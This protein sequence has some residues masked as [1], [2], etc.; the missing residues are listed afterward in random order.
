MRTRD[1][2]SL[3]TGTLRAHR[4]RTFLAILGIAVGVAAVILLT[5][6]GQGVREFVLSQFTKFGSNIIIVLPKS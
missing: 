4:L 2:I 5:S 3:T 6:I 1:F